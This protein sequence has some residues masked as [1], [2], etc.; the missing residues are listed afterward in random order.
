MRSRWRTTSSTSFGKEF[1][2]RSRYRT[3]TISMLVLHWFLGTALVCFLTQAWHPLKLKTLI[4]LNKSWE[5][6]KTLLT[7]HEQFFSAYISIIPSSISPP[8]LTG[9]S[10]VILEIFQFLWGV[11]TPQIT[12]ELK[13]RITEENEI[14]TDSWAILFFFF[15]FPY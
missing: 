5:M 14:L 1:R 11:F 12:W 10:C 7:N 9:P 2:I 4:S 6:E 15:L 8:F 13:N 3:V